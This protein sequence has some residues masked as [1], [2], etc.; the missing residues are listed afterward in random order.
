MDCRRITEI[1][2][3]RTRPK[4]LLKTTLDTSFEL[5]AMLENALSVSFWRRFSLFALRMS[6]YY[7]GT[8]WAGKGPAIPYC[9]RIPLSETNLS[10]LFARRYS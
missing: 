4:T 2:L 1:V 10:L 8:S 3:L 6:L 7:A 9:A 5:E